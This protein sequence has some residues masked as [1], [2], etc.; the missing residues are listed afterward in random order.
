MSSEQS[1]SATLDDSRKRKLENDDDKDCAKVKIAKPSLGLSLLQS[2]DAEDDYMTSDEESTSTTSKFCADSSVTRNVFIEEMTDEDQADESLTDHISSVNSEA[3]D[4]ASLSVFET[5]NPLSDTLESSIPVDSNIEDNVAPAIVDVK[6]SVDEPNENV[7]NIVIH[8]FSANEVHVVPVE[9]TSDVNV[10]VDVKTSSFDMKVETDPVSAKEDSVNELEVNK[11]KQ[12]DD[13][14]SSETS[15]SKNVDSFQTSVTNKNES[16]PDIRP[17]YNFSVFGT[18]SEIGSSDERVSSKPA[19]KVKLNRS[20]FVR[21]VDESSN[22]AKSSAITSSPVLSSSS[23]SDFKPV[24]HENFITVKPKVEVA[25]NKVPVIDQT[26]EEISAKPIEIV[27]NMSDKTE[28]STDLDQANTPIT[29]ENISVETFDMVQSL[30]DTDAD[31]F[32][33]AIADLDQSVSEP[34]VTK[35]SDLSSNFIEE[36]GSLVEG[37]IAKNLE[38]V[39]QSMEGMVESES[40][41]A[42]INSPFETEPVLI[43]EEIVGPTD[44]LRRD[45]HDENLHDNIIEVIDQDL[46]VYVIK[47]E[48]HPDSEDG[49]VEELKSENEKIN[50]TEEVKL[51]ELDVAE[52]LKNEAS[53]KAAEDLVE[54][55][56]DENSIIQES[57]NGSIVVEELDNENTVVEELSDANAIVEE[58]KDKNS[59]VEESK[60]ENPIVEET[61]RENLV[62]EESNENPIIDSVEK[63]EN[64]NVLVDVDDSKNEKTDA[65]PLALDAHERHSFDSDESLDEGDEREPVKSTV[66]IRNTSEPPHRPLKIIIRKKEEKLVVVEDI[67]RLKKRGRKSAKKLQKEKSKMKGEEN[68]KKIV[69]TD[70]RADSEMNI[71]V[72]EKV[73][74]T[75]GETN[76]EFEP[77]HAPE[78][79]E[80]FEVNAENVS[81]KFAIEKT[82]DGE[83]EEEAVTSA[84]SKISDSTA[85]QSGQI[86]GEPCLAAESDDEVFKD[87][88]ETFEPVSAEMDFEKEASVSGKLSGPE[89]PSLLISEAA[90]EPVV[91][92]VLISAES[93]YNKN[94]ADK[95]SMK[96]DQHT[97]VEVSISDKITN[98]PME[99]DVEEAS[100]KTV[101]EVPSKLE[102]ALTRKLRGVK[103]VETAAVVSTCLQEVSEIDKTAPEAQPKEPPPVKE[104]LKLHLSVQ[105]NR[106]SIK[107]S[108]TAEAIVAPLPET[109]LLP[110]P[111]ADPEV[112]P[113]RVK[114]QYRKRPKPTIDPALLTEEK[115]Y[116]L[117]TRTTKNPPE[118]LTPKKTKGR[119]SAAVVAAAATATTV[120]VPE[121]TPLP[122]ISTLPKKEKVPRE[123]PL[124]VTVEID[125]PPDKK[126]TTAGKV[127]PIR[128]KIKNPGVTIECTSKYSPVTIEKIGGPE[129]GAMSENIVDILEEARKKESQTI[130]SQEQPAWSGTDLQRVERLLKESNITITPVSSASPLSSAEPVS[131][132]PNS[133]LK[134]ILSAV[135]EK[136]A[137]KLL[138]KAPSVSPSS[139]STIGAASITPIY[140]DSKDTSADSSF[141]RNLNVILKPLDFEEQ[142]S[143]WKISKPG[144]EMDV[145]RIPS[146]VADQQKHQPVD[147]KLEIRKKIASSE[148]RRQIQEPEVVITMDEATPNLEEVHQ[149][150]TRVEGVSESKPPMKQVRRK[151]RSRPVEITIIKPNIE[152]TDENQNSDEEV[153]CRLS[154]K[155][156]NMDEFILPDST[157]PVVEVTDTSMPSAEDA[158]QEFRSQAKFMLEPKAEAQSTLEQKL[159]AQVTLGSE[160]EDPVTLEPEVEARLSLESKAEVQVMLD[161]TDEAQ[162]VLAKPAKTQVTMPPQADVFEAVVKSEIDVL[163]HIA[164]AKIDDVETESTLKVE[165]V[166]PVAE[167]KS[168]T[169]TPKLEHEPA[170]TSTQVKPDAVISSVCSSV[171]DVSQATK[172]KITAPL[173]TTPEVKQI[174]TESKPKTG[175]QMPD[176]LPINKPPMTLK[177]I[178]IPP[179]T[180]QLAHM[181]TLSMA[182]QSQLASML[183][184]AT[185]VSSQN[186]STVPRSPVTQ[187]PAIPP[188]FVPLTPQI[189]LSVAPLTPKMLQDALSAPQFTPS[190]EV[191]S[192]ASF[193]GSP[194]GTPMSAM[195]M[196]PSCTSQML[197]S[198]VNTP[199]R[200]FTDSATPSYSNL[201]PL[202][203]PKKRGRPTKAMVAAREAY[204]QSQ[205]AMEG[206]KRQNFEQVPTTTD[207]G[208]TPQSIPP[209]DESSMSNMSVDLLKRKFEHF[210]FPFKFSEFVLNNE[211]SGGKTANFSEFSSIL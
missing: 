6:G 156:E 188:Q 8:E 51:L 205:E 177:S 37:V 129:K 169:P 133:I 58:K 87:A 122:V 49:T 108:I 187:Q 199:S 200:S 105:G 172:P 95:K 67:P 148:R 92:T 178:Q 47:D 27:A 190:Q 56:M 10:T 98:E 151:S 104:N 97:P 42:K 197:D 184:Q 208:S 154:S 196:T 147:V 60:Y 195:S 70:E 116:T 18:S 9:S 138:H 54:E 45:E 180:S 40:S 74:E 33:K 34:L 141:A 183:P 26:T 186:E 153:T 14:F 128:L 11:I 17:D 121:Q 53:I 161:S 82:D 143:H 193:M 140:G 157:P 152:V 136:S 91:S 206:F 135:K 103:K 159:K 21:S 78:K 38:N 1:S 63:L 139:S 120:T 109:A 101:S 83:M 13:K 79:A 202:I 124:P 12:T 125:S 102:Q 88:M 93:D 39:P 62:T 86:A 191:S 209:S 24:V 171:G 176:L 210:A 127:R 149:S 112:P 162:A 73:G 145:T 5:N 185:P 119:K 85:L 115:S 3:A 7:K 204:R 163:E 131:P 170:E 113:P 110:S 30:T 142:L 81:V 211:F 76:E 41:A 32:V 48:K 36:N 16:K 144:R 106:V 198:S 174:T 72:V 71:A 123:A 68:K 15:D 4:G 132:S 192:T 96:N 203:F 111:A 46:D 167:P 65:L 155:S 126:V 44:I 107:K 130:I 207:A 179:I 164:D 2:Y 160:A 59:L 23:E 66:E 50:F 90:V 181:S 134:P 100:A 158:I 165:K 194:M 55:F 99:V 77:A 31:V 168:E 25:E 166:E 117:R 28:Y 89:Q 75:L 84:I 118:D 61:K 175:K 137:R 114:R 189:K 94:I 146:P 69:E 20:K 19:K 22:E 173:Q 52:E 201:P 80:V 57:T 150:R 182:T 64:K 43:D 35:D 29:D